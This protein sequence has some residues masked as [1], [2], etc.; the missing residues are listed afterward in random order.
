MTNKT[1]PLGTTVFRVRNLPNPTV[2]YGGVADGGLISGSDTRI[3]TK[4]GPEI[5]LTVDFKIQSWE[6]IVPNAPITAKGTG[7]QL[8]PQ[9]VSLIRQAKKG[10]KITIMT[11]TLGPDHVLRNANGVFT[12]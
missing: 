3:F 8:T 12:L 11:K 1:V 2:Y 6:I 10:A 5:P 4:Y 9:A 7:S